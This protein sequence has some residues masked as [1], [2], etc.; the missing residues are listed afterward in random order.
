MLFCWEKRQGLGIRDAGA[1]SRHRRA[2]WSH[3][4]AAGLVAP[5]PKP[6]GLGEGGG[7]FR[8]GVS[9]LCSESGRFALRTGPVW[10]ERRLGRRR[11]PLPP[12]HFLDR[13][14]KG[15]LPAW[16]LPGL[17]SVAQALFPTDFPNPRHSAQLLLAAC[18]LVTWWPGL[19]ERQWPAPRWGWGRKKVRVEVAG[20][21]YLMFAL[22][23]LR[24]GK[25][26]ALLCPPNPEASSLG[27]FSPPFRLPC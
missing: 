6:G 12:V 13:P 4:G 5:S 26:P 10:R 8:P 17:I 15:R 1:L 2:R 20:P 25:V 9:E 18:C 3:A 7:A 14:P 22:L 23:E 27:R 16:L 24:G 11:P 21:E 19:L